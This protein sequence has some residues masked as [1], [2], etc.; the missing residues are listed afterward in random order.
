MHGVVYL[1]ITLRGQVPAALDHHIEYRVDDGSGASGAVDGGHVRVDGRPLPVLGPPLRG[2]LWVAIHS[3]TWARG[4]RRV[5]Y[6][7][8]GR[9]RIPGRFAIDWVR[10]DAQGRTTPGDPER[11]EERRLGNEGVSTVSTSGSPYT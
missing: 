8:D 10:V 11:S 9:A 6:T 3:P 7:I 2:G 4:H 5:L 1:E